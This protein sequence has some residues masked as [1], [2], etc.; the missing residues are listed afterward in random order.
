VQPAE[1]EFDWNEKKSISRMISSK[2]IDSIQN[3]SRLKYK[4]FD[5]VKYL[6]RFLCIRKMKEWGKQNNLRKHLL[7]KRGYDKIQE[8][9]DVLNLIKSSA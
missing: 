4:C 8:E 6:V 7:Y 9:L 2:I 3:R 5:V 1:E